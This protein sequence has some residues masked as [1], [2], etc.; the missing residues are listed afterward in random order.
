MGAIAAVGVVG[1]ATA[2][3]PYVFS[4]L[5]TGAVNDRPQRGPLGETVFYEAADSLTVD[6]GS[7]QAHLMGKVK[8]R[9]GTM[10]LQS[11]QAYQNWK[12]RKLRALP[13]TD[14]LGHAVDTPTFADG[15]QRFVADSM[16]YDLV[17]GRGK[18]SELVT[19]EG[20]AYVIGR[21]VQRD[22]SGDMYVRNTLFTTCSD[23]RHPHFYLELGKAKL[24]PDRRIVTGPSR[25]VA[26]GIPLPIGLPFAVI[27][28]MKGQKA[29]VLFPEYGNSPQFGFF[30]RNGGYYWPLGPHADL[31]VRG[32]IYAYGG[33]RI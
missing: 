26:L 1:A 11:G 29:G 5:D 32:D 16:E 28:L 20:E 25:L 2:E 9:F 4:G 19:R 6:F 8:I 33:W 24:I 3:N 17:A 14:S 7:G 31:S 10:E 23:T 22:T 13:L 15:N 21:R 12:T 30:L 18:I 27:P